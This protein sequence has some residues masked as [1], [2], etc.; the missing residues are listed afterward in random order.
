MQVWE[1]V[2]RTTQA[3][4]IGQNSWHRFEIHGMNDKKGGSESV[5]T[6]QEAIGIRVMIRKVASTCRCDGAWRSYGWMKKHPTKLILS[7]LS[8]A[9][10]QLEPGK[11]GA[12]RSAWHLHGMD[13]LPLKRS[14]ARADL[15]TL[16]MMLE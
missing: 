3:P 13:G 11:Q 16:G 15:H 2:V 5:P 12:S 10:T 14:L 1:K 6:V 9:Q 4:C 8:R 7:C